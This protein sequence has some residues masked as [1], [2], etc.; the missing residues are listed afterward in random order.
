MARDIAERKEFTEVVHLLD[1]PPVTRIPVQEHTSKK[2]SHSK[3]R[4]KDSNTSQ[5]SSHK[6]KKD[7]HK[8]VIKYS[9]TVCITIRCIF[10][11]R[12]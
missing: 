8:K 10:N 2:H 7:K 9:S 12:K 6:E 4:E 1:N 11:V 5:E 3:K